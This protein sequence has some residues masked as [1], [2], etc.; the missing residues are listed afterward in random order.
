[1]EKTEVEISTTTTGSTDLTTNLGFLGLEVSV[2]DDALFVELSF[3][4]FDFEPTI[5]F[6]EEEHTEPF[7]DLEPMELND[8]L[9]SSL[10]KLDTESGYPIVFHLL[11][12]V[13]TMCTSLYLMVLPQTKK[14]KIVPVVGRELSSI[15]GVL[16]YVCSPMKRYHFHK[17]LPRKGGR[18]RG[19]KEKES[20][21][22]RKIK[23]FLTVY[24]KENQDRVKEE[25]N[26]ENATNTRSTNKQ[27][28][29]SQ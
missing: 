16:F 3:L 23:S 27:V 18:K 25:K 21:L 26:N 11:N 10:Q 29:A 24:A 20:A 14:A 6:K 4:S 7:K 9:K 17:S 28:R 13:G 12:E 8:S 5:S 22:K 2:E 1:M 15:T 19:R